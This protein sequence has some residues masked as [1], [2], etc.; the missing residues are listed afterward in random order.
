MLSL[1][2]VKQLEGGDLDLGELVKRLTEALIDEPQ[3]N[4]ILQLTGDSAVLGIE[5]LD[6]VSEIISR[7]WTPSAEFL[8]RSGHLVRY[9]PPERI[10][11]SWHVVFFAI[12]RLSWVSIHPSLL[13]DTPASPGSSVITLRPFLVNGLTWTTP[14]R[15]SQHLRP[16]M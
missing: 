10:Q 8:S 7:S 6:K 11:V 14:P 2:N 1:L 4:G 5:C 15:K 3:R 13:L 9:L 16:P 12:S